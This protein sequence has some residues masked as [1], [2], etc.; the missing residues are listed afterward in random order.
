M[1]DIYAS[2]TPDLSPCSTLLSDWL[3]SPRLSLCSFMTVEDAV[4]KNMSPEA[5]KRDDQEKEAPICVIFFSD[6]TSDFHK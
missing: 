1:I 4:I 3:L 2:G 5:G 6:I